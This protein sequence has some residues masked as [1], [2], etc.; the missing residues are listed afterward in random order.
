MPR[1]LVV[2]GDSR[3]LDALCLLLRGSGYE[4]AGCQHDHQ[5]LQMLRQQ[6]FDLLLCETELDGAAFVAEALA[7]SPDLVAVSMVDRDGI[8]SVAAAM[9][10]GVLDYILRP[11]EINEIQPI[12]T[13]ALEI[14][15]LR[16]ENGALILKAA[17]GQARI[18]ALNQELDTLAG[19]IA[20]DLQAVL[21]V[22]EGF[23][24]VLQRSAAA[25]L[26]DRE[27]HYLERLVE[28]ST[29]GNL[30]VN[31][32]MAY[33]RLG[34]QAMESRA[35]DLARVLLRAQASIERETQGRAIEWSIGELPVVLG[36]AGL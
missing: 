14:G 11:F 1:L 18:Q 6:R 21:Q 20:H 5:A 32:L 33:G 24:T 23:A 16:I 4:V 13:R 29:R 36:D 12:L 22:T 34:A 2:E 27:K 26:D 7:I 31:D 30:L 17:Q 10:V 19:R 3:H 9:T 35:V 25:K 8:H 28:T 15:R